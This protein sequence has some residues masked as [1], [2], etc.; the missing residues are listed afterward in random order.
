MDG[1]AWGGQRSRAKGCSH[2][3]SS[4]G[5]LR[6]RGSQGPWGGRGPARIL[7]GGCTADPGP[8]E[9]P[10]GP[11]RPR[12]LG[13]AERW[14]PG[15]RDEAAPQGPRVRRAREGAARPPPRPARAVT[16]PPPRARQSPPAPTV[17]AR[18]HLTP[19]NHRP[20]L[21]AYRSGASRRAAFPLAARLSVS[22]QCP[23]QQAPGRHRQGHRGAARPP[24]APPA[25]LQPWPP[26][27]GP[28]R[29]V[30]PPG[31][32]AGPTGAFVR[33]AR[34]PSCD[35]GPDHRSH[36]APPVRH[37]VAPPL[38]LATPL[39]LVPMRLRRPA[40]EVTPGMGAG[41]WRRPWTVAM[42]EG[43]PV[44]PGTP[45]V[46]RNRHR[47]LRIPTMAWV[48]L[49]WPEDL[50]RGVEFPLP[51]ETSGLWGYPS[52]GDSQWGLR[53]SKEVP[54][55]LWG[56]GSFLPCGATSGMPDGRGDEECPQRPRP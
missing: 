33:P 34:S 24:R 55:E 14:G 28:H 26:P 8:L 56:S 3:C 20:L 32:D 22:G 42:A 37:S 52:V 6:D 43:P 5:H 4:S 53:G 38:A 44:Q 36:P 39:R 45:T 46:T 12:G 29:P 16:P 19:A 1:E 49:S 7:C 13:R 10:G 17:W 18:L 9:S 48:P 54:G 15:G 40:R 51:W 41:Y 30:P 23:P 27:P 21:A 25:P 50:H 11:R 2:S 31:P 47:A 35:S